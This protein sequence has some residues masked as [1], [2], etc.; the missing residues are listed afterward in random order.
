MLRKRKPG[1]NW[2]SCFD[3]DEVKIAP[4]QEIRRVKIG[5]GR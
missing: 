3:A 4:L 2:L 5:P 1:T